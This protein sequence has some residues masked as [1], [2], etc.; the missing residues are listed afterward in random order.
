MFL[1]SIWEGLDL[2]LTPSKETCGFSLIT[3]PPNVVLSWKIFPTLSRLSYC[4]YLIHANYQVVQS[5]TERTPIYIADLTEVGTLLM[6]EGHPNRKVNQGFAI[7]IYTGWKK[8][9]I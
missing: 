8:Q 7:G 6:A 4:I 3:G 5:F 1:T 2:N 9:Q